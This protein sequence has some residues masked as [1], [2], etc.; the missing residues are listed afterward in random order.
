MTTTATNSTPFLATHFPHMCSH[1]EVEGFTFQDIDTSVNVIHDNDKDDVHDIDE[2]SMYLASVDE[3]EIARDIDDFSALIRELD[4]KSSEVLFDDVLGDSESLLGNAKQ[5]AEPLSL[6]PSHTRDGSPSCMKIPP[7][8]SEFPLDFLHPIDPRCMIVTPIFKALDARIPV[9]SIPKMDAALDRF[10]NAYAKEEKQDAV[11][12][13]EAKCLSPPS[14]PTPSVVS[15]DLPFLQEPYV[16]NPSKCWVCQSEKSSQR[17][18][19]L[20][21]FVEKRHRRNWR[22]GARYS[23]RSKVASSRV[24]EGGRFV[25]KC[26]WVAAT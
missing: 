22:R 24:R 10:A 14:S 16:H 7:L 3:D 15:C 11:L 26:E 13:S 1:V 9:V 18:S 2:F 6:L 25:T 21:R 19:I 23:A 8:V 4:Q 17:K 20:H 12:F 5:Y